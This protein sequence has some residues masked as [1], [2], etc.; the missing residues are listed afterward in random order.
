MLI[1]DGRERRPCATHKP[2][3]KNNQTHATLT[4]GALQRAERD[5][6]GDARRKRADKAGGDKEHGAEQEDALAAEAVAGGAP[7]DHGEADE[8]H[9]DRDRRGDELC[10]GCFV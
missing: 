6:H 5:E 9:V 2:T 10:F 1:D 7:H 8:E 4:D 3:H